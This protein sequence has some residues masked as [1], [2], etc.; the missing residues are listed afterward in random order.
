MNL[1]MIK[2]VDSVKFESSSIRNRTLPNSDFPRNKSEQQYA[3]KEGFASEN[4]S[5]A[6]L[7]EGESPCSSPPSFTTSPILRPSYKVESSSPGNGRTSERSRGARPPARSRTPRR[8][9]RWLTTTTTNSP[10]GRGSVSSA[11]LR[12]FAAS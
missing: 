11:R 10:R 6:R 2:K 1:T 12:E 9:R 3:S 5:F 7:S 4:P 8:C